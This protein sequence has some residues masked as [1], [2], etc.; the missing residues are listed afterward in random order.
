MPSTDSIRIRRTEERG[1]GRGGVGGGGGVGLW[2]GGAFG[3]WAVCAVAAGAGTLVALAP[4]IAMGAGVAVV[5]LAIG[6]LWSAF[7]GGESVLADLFPDLLKDWQAFSDDFMKGVDEI[8]QFIQPLLDAFSFISGVG[9]TLGNMLGIGD[10][11]Q[12]VPA[13]V[14][15]NTAIANNGG[16]S[17]DTVIQVNGAASPSAVAGEVVRKAGLAPSV[18]SLAPGMRQPAVS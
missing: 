2:L 6:D 3:A 7:T 14:L 18:Q 10:V 4:W 9:G 15:N 17:G 8:M 5:V 11:S 16:N 13:S 12:A 1:E